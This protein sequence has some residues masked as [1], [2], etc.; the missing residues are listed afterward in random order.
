MPAAQLVM[1][2]SPRIPGQLL[3]D[4]GPPLSNAQTKALLDQLYRFSDR[5]AV[6]T[7]GRRVFKDISETED[8]THVYVKVDKPESLCPKWE[9]PYAIVSRPSRSTVEV[10]LGLFKNGEMRKSIYHWTSCKV[11]NLRPGAA[12]ASRPRLGRPPKKPPLEI[13]HPEP[14]P[15][16]TAP[17]DDSNSTDAESVGA[18]SFVYSEPASQQTLPVEFFAGNSNDIVST[19]RPVRST[20]NLNPN[21]KT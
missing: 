4:P 9:G 17:D 20:R 19:N 14:D 13:F 7:S 10:K 16:A 12:E 21:Y 3:G 2:M 8:A 6:Q 11:A 15:H 5:P 1:Q 18:E